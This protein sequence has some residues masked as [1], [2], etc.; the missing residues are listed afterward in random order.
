MSPHSYESVGKRRRVTTTALKERKPNI[1]PPPAAAAAAKK[2]KAPTVAATKPKP[3][4]KAA[5]AA[6]VVYED[7][8]EEEGGD[9][10]ITVDTV[11]SQEKVSQ[12]DENELNVFRAKVN[13]L[14]NSKED[15]ELDLVLKLCENA[16]QLLQHLQNED[17]VFVS[18]GVVYRV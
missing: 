18:E 10:N 1:I 2:K 9:L 4:A 3:P 17:S 14:M 8:Q 16:K 11:S 12:V 5:P 6:V 7:K 15:V 13:E